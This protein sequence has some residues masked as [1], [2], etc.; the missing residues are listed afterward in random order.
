MSKFA[1]KHAVFVFVF[2]LV[3]FV[4]SIWLNISFV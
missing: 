2:L 1:I 3:L 4:M